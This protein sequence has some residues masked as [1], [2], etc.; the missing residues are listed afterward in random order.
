MPASTH[1]RNHRGD[2][3]EAQAFS[4]SDAKNAFGRV[5]D[6]VERVGM[7]TITRHDEPK[8]VLLSM[9]EYRSLAGARQ[10]SLEAMAGEF[11]AMLARMQIP[12]ARDAMQSAFVTP[13]GELGRIAVKGARGKRGR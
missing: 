6:A 11:D 5:L 2:L 10:D 4:A 8:A 9:D 12:G 7:V 13:A 3:I 1:Y